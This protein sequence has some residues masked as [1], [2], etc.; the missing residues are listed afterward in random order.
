MRLQVVLPDPAADPELASAAR[1]AGLPCVAARGAGLNLERVDGML[2]LQLDGD[3]S[4]MCVRVDLGVARPGSTRR[5]SLIARAVGGHRG[6]LV[7]DATAGLG[8]DAAELAHLG[9]RVVACERHPVLALMLREAT[10]RSGSPFAVHGG[11][12]GEILATLARAER[13]RA[14]CLDPMFGADGVRA[15]ARKAA[16][17][18]QHLLG[19]GS[20]DEDRA[21]LTA[22]WPC[23]DRIV[24][25]RPRRAPPIAPGV[26]FTVEGKAVRFDVYLTT[27]RAVPSR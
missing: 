13:P 6:D 4:P 16:Q 3:A 10:L 15:R 19:S 27:G 1:A 12:A 25:K 5:T 9:Y 20:P 7:F 8:G 22:A 26:N 23:A 24:V 21:M 18:L 11:D 2:T 14:V 17:V